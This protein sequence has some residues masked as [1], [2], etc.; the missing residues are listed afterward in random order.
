MESRPSRRQ[1]NPSPTSTAMKPSRHLLIIGFYLLL[2]S[3]PI[4]YWHLGV[5]N[6]Q[7]P[8]E[9]KSD[10]FKANNPMISIAETVKYPGYLFKEHVLPKISSYSSCLD[11]LDPIHRIVDIGLVLAYTSTS[12]LLTILIFQSRQRSRNHKQSLPLITSH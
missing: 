10:W 5:A 7:L 11:P 4:V 6:S 2:F 1:Q 8:D 9:L 12:W 3:I